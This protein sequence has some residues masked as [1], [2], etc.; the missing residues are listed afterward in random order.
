[1]RPAEPRYD[2]ALSFAGEQRSYVNDVAE[3]L[4]DVG[5]RVFYDDYE[6]TAMWGKDLYAHLDYIYR[7]ASR[8]CVL[9]IS[10]DYAKKVWT[11]HE[12][13]SAQ[14][15]ALEENSEYVLPVRFDETA[16]PGLRPTIGYLDLAHLSPAQLAERIEEKLGPRPARPGFPS[17]TPRLDLSLEKHLKKKKIKERRKE[18]REVAY[19]FY[20]AMSRMDDEERRSVAGVLAFG[21]WAELPE[22]VHISLNYLSRM[23][24]LPPAQIMAALAA[25]RP[26]NFRASLRAP[27]YHPSDPGALIP[28][29]RD[30]TL[31]FW[32]PAEPHVKDATLI[33]YGAVQAASAHYCEDH[34]LDRVC[35]LD[36]HL[37]GV[38]D[39]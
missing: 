15:R 13:Q 17:K 21:C 12:R 39:D 16:V 4:R 5:V 7:E 10:E 6:K 32:S 38:I 29:D 35:A 20:S 26:L 37:L 27:V 11:N 23:V 33:A 36:F 19:S 24:K 1:M 28:N 2:V 14:A 22:N 3:A 31:N 18:I 30:I 34:G 9:F 25:V 8:Y